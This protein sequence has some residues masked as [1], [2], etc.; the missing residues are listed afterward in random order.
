MVGSLRKQLVN[1]C[2]IL[3]AETPLISSLSEQL[4]VQSLLAN[5]L[6]EK[7]TARLTYFTFGQR[8]SNEPTTC[9]T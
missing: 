3:G 9:Q 2:E 8:D 6:L 1:G 5:N 4:T 7:R